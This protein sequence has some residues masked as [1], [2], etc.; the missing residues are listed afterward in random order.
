MSK[1]L[2]S[3]AWSLYWSDI[4]PILLTLVYVMGGAGTA[5]AMNMIPNINLGP[6][7]TPVVSGVLIVCL[8]AAHSFFTNTQQLPAPLV[9]R[10]IALHEDG[11]SPEQI[12][13][14][15][16]VIAAIPKP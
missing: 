12:A 9:D 13:A 16:K 2:G 14:D 6:T 4:K 8:K 10:V 15:P 11:K 3:P 5:A 1:I 7:W